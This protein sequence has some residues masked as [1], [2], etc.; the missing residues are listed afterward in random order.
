MC[1]V[2]SDAISNENDFGTSDTPISE[3]ERAEPLYSDY[4]YEERTRSTDAFTSHDGRNNEESHKTS[5]DTAASNLRRS[6]RVTKKPD[7]F[8]EWVSVFI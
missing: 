7:H 1:F 5:S 4:E 8:G 3:T 2:K 6:K